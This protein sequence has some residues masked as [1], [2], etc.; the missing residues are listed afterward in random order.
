MLVLP[1]IGIPASRSRVTRVASYG[2]TQPCRILEP[3]VVGRPLVAMTSLTAIGTPASR[4][5]DSPAARR[6]ST[7][8]GLGEGALGVD[9]QV[10]VHVAVDGGGAVEVGLGHLARRHA[11]LGEE[12]GELGGGG[13]GEVGGHGGF[14]GAGRDAVGAVAR[15][16]QSSSRMRGTAKRCCSARGRP[17]QRCLRGERGAHDVGAGHVDD[18]HR[19]AHRLDVGDRCLLHG[20]H[21]LEDDGQLAR[22]SCRARRRRGRCGRD[23]R[24]APRRHG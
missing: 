8:V 15:G 13:P 11:P 7:R 21:R 18:R 6:R 22:P 24:G 9:V 2:G 3:Q 12:V 5:S 10:G 16:R 19:V 14:A 4:C 17:G 23:R 1:R 20:R